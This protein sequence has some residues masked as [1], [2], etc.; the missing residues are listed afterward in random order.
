MSRGLVGTG[1]VCQTEPVPPSECGLMHEG[2][3]LRLRRRSL[4][5]GNCTERVPG[6][7]HGEPSALQKLRLRLRIPRR[8][9]VGGTSPSR[10]LNVA[11]RDDDR[12]R[13]GCTCHLCRAF[14]MVEHLM[15]ET[16]RKGHSWAHNQWNTHSPLRTSEAVVSALLD[17]LS[18]LCISRGRTKLN[19][20][21]VS[22]N[23]RSVGPV[24][25]TQLLAGG[26]Y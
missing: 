15:G 1:S 14:P 8:R 13:S 3:V 20:P 6:L 22:A 10:A 4:D 5:D 19:K 2:S 26:Y 21:F 23:A 11:W 24:K 16:T 9:Q 25:L 12:T 7:R 17:C 18:C